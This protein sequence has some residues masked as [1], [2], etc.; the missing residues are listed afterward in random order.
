M[1]TPLP[2]TII[3][4]WCWK[5]VKS[6]LLDWVTLSEINNDTLTV[7]KSKDGKEILNL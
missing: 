1:R 5:Q 6:V 7:E 3:K 4:L 2:I